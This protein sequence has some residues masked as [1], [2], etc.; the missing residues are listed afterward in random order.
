MKNEAMYRE[1]WD[2]LT[3]D[4]ASGKESAIADKLEVKLREL[5]CTVT[6][7][8]A[9][10]TFGGECGNLIGILEGELDGS[11]MLS[12]H[13]DRVPN[14]YGIQPVEKDGVL[15]SDGTT[16]L[17]ADDISGVC[18]ILE[19]VRR[20]KASGKPLSVLAGAMEVLPQVLVN[21]RVR[22]EKKHAFASDPELREAITQAEQALQGQGRVLV[23]PSGTEAL[24]RIMVEGK[25]RAQIQ[26]LVESL[27]ER[28]RR[29]LGD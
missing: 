22:E 9:G 11:V 2:L 5:G 27:A 4:S 21:V 25:D 15:Y 17:A 16:I 28:M 23:R 10:E 18:A 12:S 13:M 3:T 29:R 19:G 20:A 8:N 14:G 6:R 7:D 1:L 24:V 26:A